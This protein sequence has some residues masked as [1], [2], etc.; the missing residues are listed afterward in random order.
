LC[1]EKPCATGRL[2]KADRVRPAAQHWLDNSTVSNLWGQISPCPKS[3]YLGSGH[4]VV[5]RPRNLPA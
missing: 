3:D 5:R 2:P 4:R 1:C